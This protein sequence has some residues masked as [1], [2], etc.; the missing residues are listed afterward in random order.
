M[1]EIPRRDFE[2]LKIWKYKPSIYQ[3]RKIGNGL[4]TTYLN[5]WTI[6]MNGRTLCSQAVECDACEWRSV[7][8][9]VDTFIHESGLFIF[10]AADDEGWLWGLIARAGASAQP[11]GLA[12]ANPRR[13]L[14][15]AMALGI[16]ILWVRE[17]R[18]FTA[19][20]RA[21]YQKVSLQLH[22]RASP[23]FFRL[24]LRAV[25][26]WEKCVYVLLQAT[27]EREINVCFFYG[28]ADNL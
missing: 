3:V 11:L 23:I 13:F 12:A 25:N 26:V 8:R 16:I 27:D 28:D 15:P 17:L 2:T 14:R 5:E 7:W 21:T 9:R 10:S 4:T 19:T 6:V 18:F 1:S 22:A 24:S 20:E